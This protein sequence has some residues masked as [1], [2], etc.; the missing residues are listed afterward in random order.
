MQAQ[1]RLTALDIRQADIHLTVETARTQK[2]GVENVGAVGRGNDNYAVVRAEAIHFN[3]QLVQRLFPFIVTAAKSGAAMTSNGVNLVNK[4]D[5]R[6]FFLCLVKQI[7]H[8][9]G[10]D[11]N[12]Q[13]HKVG[14][15]NGEE[16]YI[17]LTGHCLGKQGFT[18]A[19]RADEQYALR[20]T[21]A[22]FSEF[23]RVFQEF[24]Q[25]L[26]LC[27]FLI[28]TLHIAEGDL[29]LFVR[30]KARAGLAK[31]HGLACAAIGAVD[32]IIPEQTEDHDH[33]QIRNHADPPRD[34]TRRDH[35]VI[36]KDSG[37]LLLLDQVIQIGKKQIPVRQ[38]IADDSAV[39]Q[40]QLQRIT[41]QREGL[42]LLVIEKV[43]H[44]RIF[45]AAVA[46]G[47]VHHRDCADQYNQHDYIKANTS[48]TLVF[49]TLTPYSAFRS[50]AIHLRLQNAYVRQVAIAAG[51]VKAVSHNKFIR[52]FK[53]AII[54]INR[55]LTPRRLVQQ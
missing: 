18:G 23:A 26:K 1:N 35:I 31:A 53:S 29:A 49:Q 4:H 55:H 13:L 21:R 14:T 38:E 19:G 43:Q 52:N 24:N 48:E 33:D 42:H 2:R 20:D 44:F 32:H 51:I 25:F 37:L 12:I 34:L 8:T 3:E 40:T 10:A 30:R 39:L 5:G 41:V 45:G 11:A 50:S 15:G 36:R 54:N 9:G 16:R 47:I 28:R 6:L 27:L 17:R 22:D 46:S 7:T